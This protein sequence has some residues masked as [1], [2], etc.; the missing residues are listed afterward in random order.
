MMNPPRYH[1]K[2]GSSTQNF[3]AR[4]ERGRPIHL[5]QA[6]REGVPV[7]RTVIRWLNKKGEIRLST[8]TYYRPSEL[9]GNYYGAS[10]TPLI[11]PGQT[12]TAKVYVP[13]DTPPSIQ[14]SLYV[15]D[16]NQDETHQQIGS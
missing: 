6:E 10:F 7:L 9:S 2:Y 5:L 4:G 8:R 14:A 13:A 11:Y 3:L 16:D 1:F 12:I 15:Y